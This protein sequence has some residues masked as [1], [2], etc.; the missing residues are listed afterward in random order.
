MSNALAKVP[1]LTDL[2][3]DINENHQLALMHFGQSFDHAVKAGLLLK[4]RN[5]KR[6]EVSD[7]LLAESESSAMCRRK[8]ESRLR[9]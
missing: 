3:R 8:A 1:L 6:K 2:A 4:R 7:V 9:N 5:R